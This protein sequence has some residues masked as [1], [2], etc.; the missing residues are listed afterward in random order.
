MQIRICTSLNTH[1]IIR[2][3]LAR[4][5]RHIIVTNN[6]APITNASRTMSQRSRLPFV[7]NENMFECPKRAC[8]SGNDISNSRRIPRDTMTDRNHERYASG[9]KHAK[10]SETDYSPAKSE[11]SRNVCNENTGRKVSC[12]NNDECDIVR[13]RTVGERWMH[14]VISDGQATYDRSEYAQAYS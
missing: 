2:Y 14:G 10:V 7:K 8:R 13:V 3:L 11:T 12:D 6:T 1:Y 5:C 9:K 4:C